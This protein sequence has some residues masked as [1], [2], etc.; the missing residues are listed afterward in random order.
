MLLSPSL[1]PVWV[2]GCHENPL[3]LFYTRPCP[4][5]NHFPCIDLFY[6][7]SSTSTRPL[8]FSPLLSRVV[9]RSHPRRRYISLSQPYF[10][11]FLG[12]TQRLI[13]L[14][15]T[16]SSCLHRS[17]S[18]VILYFTASTICR[19]IHI[20][21]FTTSLKCVLATKIL[22]TSKRYMGTQS[23]YCYNASFTFSLRIF[24][25]GGYTRQHPPT[26]VS[27]HSP[28]HF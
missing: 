8:I 20:I 1:S 28:L 13:C 6:T 22:H 19:Y 14:S 18:I 2:L 17:V 24:I 26:M 7:C 15:P 3:T 27:F 16:V 11:G 25:W 10:S 4:C 21:F 23:C 5:V 12:C 9:S